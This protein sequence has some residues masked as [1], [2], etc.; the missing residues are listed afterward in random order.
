MNGPIPT[1]I[2]MFRLTA[3]SRP[4]RRCNIAYALRAARPRPS[5]H[6]A[7]IDTHRASRGTPVNQPTG[8]TCG[9]RRLGGQ[10]TRVMTSD[11]F[12]PPKPKLLEIA[13][14]TGISRAV[15]GT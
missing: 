3:W 11:A 8:R 7:D 1:I 15:L 10:P 9:D 4:S 12:W 14:R 2:D 5:P 13:V 6:V